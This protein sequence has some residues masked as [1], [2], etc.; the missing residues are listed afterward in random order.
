MHNKFRFHILG[1]PHTVTNKEYTACAYTSKVHK[2]GRM[3]MARGHEVIHYGHRDSDVEC[4][5]HVTVTTN[6][7]LQKAY[8]NYDWRRNFYKFDVNDHAY[9]TFYRN[10]IREVGRRKH[11][12]DFILPFWGSGVRP[13][14]DAHPDMICVEPGIGYAGGHWARW[15]IFESYAIYHAYCNM[16]GVNWCQQDWYEAVIPNYFDPQDFEFRKEKQDYFL[17]LGRVYSGKG[18]DVAIQATEA[19][20][21]RL[22]IAGQ[23]PDNLSFPPHVEFVGYANVDLRRR[24][25]AGARGAFVP[26]QYVEPFGGVQI[27]MLMSG[28]PTIT[29][30]WG[31]FVENNLHGITG[32]RCRTF[33]QFVWATQNIDRID[34]QACRTWAENFTLDRVAPMYEEFF[35]SVMDVHTGAGWYQR[36]PERTDIDWLSK[37]YP[38]VMPR[39][40][41]PR[42]T[43]FFESEWAFGNIHHELCKYLWDPG[44]NCNLVS[45]TRQYNQQELRDLQDDSDVFVT[46]PAAWFALQ[47]NFGLEPHNVILIAHGRRDLEDFLKHFSS[48]D[49]EDFRGYAVVSSWLIDVSRE[50]GIKR[51]PD[52]VPVAINVDNYRIPPSTN[53][54]R[55][56]YAGTLN[57]LYS[58]IKRVE[59]AREAVE[60][61]GLEFVVAEGSISNYIT[62]PS[63]YR[64]VD[65]VIIS[66]AHEGACM[67]MLEAGAAG[68]LVVTTPVGHW[69]SRVGEMGSEVLPIDPVGFLEQAIKTLE[70]YRDNPAKYQQK[71]QDIQRHSQNYDWA[72]V[73]DLWADLL[74]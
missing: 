70:F 27:E 4:T 25:M 66:S 61:A 62:M 73:I 21:D 59:L 14:C 37:K 20:G 2:F 64:S 51:V 65:A 10:A 24:L 15:K 40:R 12:H 1:I 69:S 60:R 32:Y 42:V 29:T 48:T 33:D 36:H 6:R 54:R 38:Q 8:G 39:S 74:R 22:I 46:S 52:L 11:R 44:F 58:D 19:S 41:R 49:L 35:Q 53:L 67:P 16:Q 57:T 63:F 34:P 17:F 9:Q 72:Q 50:L 5:E 56:G 3:M 31:A 71:C 45:W 28:T 7:D 18:I 47:E 30:D 55:V 23:N 43:F 26:S 68:R 13:V